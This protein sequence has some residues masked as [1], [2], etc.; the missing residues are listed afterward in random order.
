MFTAANGDRPEALNIAVVLTDGDPKIFD[1]NNDIVD[2]T[3]E[4][5]EEAKQTRDSGVTVF[6][7]GVGSDVKNT[8]LEGIASEPVQDHWFLVSDLSGLEAIGNS[9][10]TAVCEVQA[11]EYNRKKFNDQ[12]ITILHYTKYVYIRLIFSNEYAKFENALRRPT[13]ATKPDGF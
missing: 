12:I 8:T 2:L 1:Q 7:I 11:S 6:A 3:K 10:K 9:I 13:D 4:T 5:I